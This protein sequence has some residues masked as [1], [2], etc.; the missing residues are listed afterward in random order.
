MVTKTFKLVELNPAAINFEHN[1]PIGSHI[2]E[3]QSSLLHPSMS[4]PVR[5]LFIIISSY[6]YQYLQT[7]LKL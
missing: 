3:Q 4:H 2:L 5:N 6:N 1:L 7:I